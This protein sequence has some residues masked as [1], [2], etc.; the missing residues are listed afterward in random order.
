MLSLHNFM[1]AG[2]PSRLQIVPFTRRTKRTQ[3]VYSA[4][5]AVRALKQ[6]F[7]FVSTI[8]IAEHFQFY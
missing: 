8:D 1:D 4:F 5:A 2:D 6:M 7:D 3:D